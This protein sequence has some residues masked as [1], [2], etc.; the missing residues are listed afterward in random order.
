MSLLS[1]GTRFRPTDAQIWHKMT[2]F[3]SISA[4]IISVCESRQVQT[5]AEGFQSHD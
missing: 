4:Q 3:G 5:T 1:H 2:N